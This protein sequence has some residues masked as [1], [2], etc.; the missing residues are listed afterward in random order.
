M[1]ESDA[2]IDTLFIPMSA[3]VV[4]LVRLI[5]TVSDMMDTFKRGSDVD[6]VRVIG[7]FSWSVN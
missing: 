3:F 7:S 1:Y 4:S 6:S 5:Y 2:T